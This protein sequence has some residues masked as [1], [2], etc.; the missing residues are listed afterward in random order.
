MRRQRMSILRSCLHWSMLLSLLGSFHVASAL[1]AGAARNVH[2]PL[3]LGAYIL[4][5]LGHQ[6][7]ISTELQQWDKW[8]GKQMSLAGMFL[9]LEDTNPTHNIAV[10]LELLRQNGYTAFINLTSKRTAAEIASG[11][12]DAGLRRMAQA[13]AAWS[14]QGEQRMAFVAPLPEMNG[15][16]ETYK[17]DP[18]NFKKAYHRMQQ[19]FTEHKVARQ[20]VRWVFAP[21]GWSK[22]AAHRFE[23][24][25]PGD[26]SVQVVAFSAYNW[27][28]CR[29][30]SWQQWQSAK[31]IYEPYIK[32]MQAMVP[33]KP[34]FIAQTAT[35][36]VTAEGAQPSVKDQWLRDS[37]A[38]LVG[39]PA[40]RAILYFNID[41]EC[42]WAIF[43]SRG[44]RA[45]GYKDA[46]NHPAMRYI[47]PPNLAQMRLEP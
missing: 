46:V 5:Y 24:Y 18:E 9:D 14:A 17:E 41:K 15:D 27:G 38:Y 44:S 39:I 33:S 28:H 40:V 26:E 31:K 13:Y 23:V 12:V 8:A 30:V 22:T 45:D 32:R 47:S 35:T 36:S 6:Q 11:T 21:N 4:P 20:A 3:L 34:I 19:I 10:P 25:Y 2:Q 29:S 16:W 1:D 43:R 7:V 42:D 37:Y